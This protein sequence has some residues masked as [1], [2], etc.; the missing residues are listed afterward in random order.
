M[1]TKSPLVGISAAVR[2]LDHVDRHGAHRGTLSLL[3]R[4]AGLSRTALYN[5]DNKIP[6]KRLRLFM[7]ISGLPVEVLRPDYRLAFR[8]EMGVTPERFFRAEPVATPRD[9]ART[10][11]VARG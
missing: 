11:R 1:K 2:S 3:A 8:R 9:I 6:L 4:K 7:Q 5:W 10:K